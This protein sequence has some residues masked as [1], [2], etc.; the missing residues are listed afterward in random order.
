MQRGTRLIWM[1]VSLL[2]VAD[3]LL[4]HHLQL[5]FYHWTPLASAC[6]VIS[7]I[8]LFYHLTGRSAGL[9][10]AAYWTLLW[11]LF[12]NAGTVLIYIAAACGGPRTTETLAAADAAL[13]FDWQGW[14]DFLAPHRG[15]R[16]ALWLAYSS[17]FPQILLSIFWFSS[18]RPLT[19]RITSCC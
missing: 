4:C 3:L 15:L 6:A 2:A 11:L 8:G 17:L 13:G 16:F 14:Y 12:V 18:D 7:A 9:A 10:R 5:R 1:A 19:I